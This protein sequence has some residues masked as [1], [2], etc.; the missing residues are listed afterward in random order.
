M[1][2]ILF[3]TLLTFLAGCSSSLPR[4]Q[5]VLTYYA[6]PPG[7]M[8]YGQNGDAWGMAPQQRVYTSDQFRNGTQVKLGDVIAIWPSG[9]K[10]KASLAQQRRPNEEG[11]Y[12][13]TISRPMDAPGLEKD[14][15]YAAQ[16]QS[17]E[18]QNRAARAQE[19]AAD[20]AAYSAYSQMFKTTN[21]TCNNIGGMVSCTSR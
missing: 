19:D 9:A 17:I 20:M 8:L 13:F 2:K 21:T 14:M 12:Q 3:L 7:A 1:K 16:L 11:Y 15:N 6:Q 5:V 10:A 4:N 18:A